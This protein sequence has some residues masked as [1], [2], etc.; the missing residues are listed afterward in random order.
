M[1]RAA[2]RSAAFG[3]AAPTDFFRRRSAAFGG[4]VASSY[5][6]VYHSM[7][8]TASRAALRRELKAGK[9]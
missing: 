6:S 9:S 5:F 4:A 8:Y 7:G 1:G 2:Q 3:G